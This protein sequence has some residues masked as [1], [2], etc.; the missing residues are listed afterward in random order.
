MVD[1]DYWLNLEPPLSPDDNDIL[2]YKRLLEG[3][4]KPIL[5]L[6]V[7]KKL[8]P[9][10]DF[11]IDLSPVDI[12]KPVIKEDWFKILDLKLEIG[13]I[14]GDGVLNLTGEG[15]LPYISKCCN[16]FIT[17]VF[18]EKLP[19]MRVATHF[20]NYFPGAEVF[21]TANNIAIVKWDYTIK[22][23]QQSLA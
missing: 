16:A 8:V 11:A 15:L 22:K 18:L 19:Q 10:C 1:N 13:T 12:G 17:R 9:L 14:I 2:I 5:L 20:P 23:P 4:K 6:G 7:T 3:C 21:K